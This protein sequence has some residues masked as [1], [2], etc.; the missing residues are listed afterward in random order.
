MPRSVTFGAGPH[1]LVDCA[2]KALALCNRE[3]RLSGGFFGVE[4]CK[5]QMLLFP[6]T[7]CESVD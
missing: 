2:L 3:V 5:E 7:L 6:L 4:S 1:R